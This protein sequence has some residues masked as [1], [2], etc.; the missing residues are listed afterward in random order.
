MGVKTEEPEDVPTVRD[1]SWAPVNLRDFL[2]TVELTEPHE[3]V[4]MAVG[5]DDRVDM[6]GPAG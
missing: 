6:R 4:I 1:Y 3:M 5:P 2:D